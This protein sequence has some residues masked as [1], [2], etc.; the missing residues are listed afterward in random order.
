MIYPNLIFLPGAS[1]NTAFWQPVIEKIS[2]D[3]T[4]KVIAY[5]SFGGYAAHPSVMSFDDLQDFVIDQIQIPSIVIAQSMGGVFAVQAALQKSTLI[6]GLVLVA[7]SGGIDLSLFDTLDWRRQYQETFQ[8]PDWFTGHHEYLDDQLSQIQCPILLIW[9]D[10][11][12]ISPIAIG[13][14]LQ[15]QL[16]QSE[17]HIIAKGQH[18][19]AHSHAHQVSQLI[20][21]FVEKF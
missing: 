6:Q 8:V 15:S 17:L 11:D 13:R 12:P 10:A 5:P 1:G 21:A 2:N 20:T 7:T 3:V 18:D 14:Y 4:K 9:G 19:L 16:S